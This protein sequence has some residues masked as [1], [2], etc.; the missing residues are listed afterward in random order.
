MEGGDLRRQ[1][2]V[3]ITAFRGVAPSGAGDG[4]RTRVTSL[5][6]WSST[7]ELRPQRAEDIPI[8]SSI[9][10]FAQ[11]GKREWLE[12]PFCSC[13]RKTSWSKLAR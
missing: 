8:Y 13:S 6:G 7:I 2:G 4:N 1:A 5:E 3:G 9:R 11:P 10:G 12:N